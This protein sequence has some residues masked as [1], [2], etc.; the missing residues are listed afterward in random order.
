MSFRIFYQKTVRLIC[1]DSKANGIM[2]LR[3][4]MNIESGDEQGITS[5]SLL[6][7]S[8]IYLDIVLF[9]KFIKIDD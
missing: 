3:V 9:H 5:I 7:S 1:S 6:V 2:T 8:V 4:S